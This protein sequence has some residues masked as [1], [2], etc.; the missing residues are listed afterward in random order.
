MISYLKS[1]TYIGLHLVVIR[2]YEVQGKSCLK[3]GEKIYEK[4]LPEFFVSSC[5]KT[6][7][8]S[9][10]IKKENRFQII[11]ELTLR[12]KVHLKDSIPLHE[13]FKVKA[14]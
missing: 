1:I 12:L 5:L 9:P 10:R 14:V 4:E 3:E 8:F 7:I 2:S 13:Q 6:P 11:S